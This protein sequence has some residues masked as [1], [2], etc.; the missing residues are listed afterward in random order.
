MKKV[1]ADMRLVEL[2]YF[3]TQ[4]EAAAT[5]MA[6]RVR[7]G[8]D[9][10]TVLDKPGTPVSDETIFHV[11]TS[12]P[13]VSRGGYKLAGALDDFD[14]DV[15]GARTLDIG[16]STG[17]FTD[18]LLQ[19]GAVSVCAVDV[20]YGQLAWKLRTDSRV[21]VWDRT[22]FRLVDVTSLGAPF[23]IVVADVSFISLATIAHQ[24]ERCISDKGVAVLLVKPQFELDSADIGDKGVVSIAANHV[25]ALVQSCDVAQ[26]NGLHVSNITYSPIKGPEGNIEFWL[27]LSHRVDGALIGEGLKLK[28]EDCVAQAHLALDK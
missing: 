19:R 8:S 9:A 4:Q 26:S 14:V 13:Y 11:I 27:M 5:I 7:T 6:G 22:N 17:G 21:E 16:A 12:S 15:S 10:Q 2:G 3:D 1:R 18:C 25:K 24:I 20:G 28:I 23:D